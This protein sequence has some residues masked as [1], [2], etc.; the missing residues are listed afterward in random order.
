MFICL[1]TNFTISVTFSHLCLSFR[2]PFFLLDQNMHGNGW[3][4]DIKFISIHVTTMIHKME[5]LLLVVHEGN[6]SNNLKYDKK[7]I[8]REMFVGCVASVLTLEIFQRSNIDSTH[9]IFF[10]C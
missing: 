5:S 8:N 2:S 9:G 3:K 1:M 4:R 10:T 6:P 7:E